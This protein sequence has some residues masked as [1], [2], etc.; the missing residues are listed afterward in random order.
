MWL[1]GPH[2]IERATY[3]WV[4]IMWL[5]GHQWLRGHHITDDIIVVLL[6]DYIGHHGL[7]CTC[8]HVGLTAGVDVNSGWLCS[9]S[10]ACSPKPPGSASPLSHTEWLVT[11]VDTVIWSP[12][13]NNNILL[14]SVTTISLT[15]ILY[16]LSIIQH[17]YISHSQIKTIYRL[18]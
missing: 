17:L 8:V 13:N 16:R 6:L 15:T 3:H 14:S 5:R 2:V 18:K 1:K 12:Y 4:G 9:P 10:W 11:D 7:S